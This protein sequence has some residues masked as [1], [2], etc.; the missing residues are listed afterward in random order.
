VTT[1]EEAKENVF[2]ES[3]DKAITLD[4]FFDMVW[5]ARQPEIDKQ[6]RLNAMGQ[7]RELRLMAMIEEL[8][9]LYKELIVQRT[10]IPKS[11]A[12]ELL[13]KLK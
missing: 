3:L 9:R 11:K 8:N 1:R 4:E 5:D 10:Y 6:C 13:E 7:E 2:T 12:D